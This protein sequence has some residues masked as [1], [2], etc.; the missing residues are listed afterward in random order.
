MVVYVFG[1]GFGFGCFGVGC[2]IL[3][4]LGVVMVD[5]LV[6]DVLLWWLEVVDG[7]LDSVGLV[8]ELGVEY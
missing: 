2:D 4:V 1:V 5:G 3:S 8:V 6:V 7:G